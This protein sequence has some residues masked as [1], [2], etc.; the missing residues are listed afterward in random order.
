MVNITYKKC[1]KNPFCIILGIIIIFIIILF[2][3]KIS[4]KNVEKFKAGMRECKGDVCSMKSDTAYCMKEMNPDYFDIPI[5]KIKKEYINDKNKLKKDLKFINQEII[6]RTEENDSKIYN[7]NGQ[8]Y[9]NCIRIGNKETNYDSDNYKSDTISKLRYNI[10]ESIEKW[11]NSILENSHVDSNSR[12][13]VPSQPKP[14]PVPVKEPET[15]ILNEY[16]SGLGSIT[17]TCPAGKGLDNDNRYY[18]CIDM[19][20]M[21]GDNQYFMQ[22]YS[23]SNSLCPGNLKNENGLCI[24]KN[25]KYKFLYKNDIKNN[26]I[27]KLNNI[28]PYP[29]PEGG[30]SD[31]NPD[32]NNRHFDCKKIVFNDNTIIDGYED[33]SNFCPAGL[34]RINVGKSILCFTDDDISNL[35]KCDS[36][37][38]GMNKDGICAQCPPGEYSQPSNGDVYCTKCPEGT[39]KTSDGGSC[40]CPSGK[41]ITAGETCP[42]QNVSAVGTAPVT[43]TQSSGTND[44]TRGIVQG[45]TFGQVD[46]L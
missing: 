8:Y 44:F 39:T 41:F 31:P 28:A 3:L 40:Q 17:F 13:T 12:T 37:G 4:K 29:C 24:P 20:V 6:R 10:S 42:V 5:Y 34:D 14:K 1:L 38:L 7:Q 27:Q 11:R 30:W 32:A 46:I 36:S 18:D 16:Q 9:M 22:G 21:D 25:S 33:A 35:K 43:Q 23:P 26:Y 2:I 15:L 45:L 19:K